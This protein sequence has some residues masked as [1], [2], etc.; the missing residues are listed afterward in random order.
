MKVTTVGGA[1]Q[2]LHLSIEGA[3]VVP[4]FYWVDVEP[5]YGTYVAMRNEGGYWI[6]E[7]RPTSAMVKIQSPFAIELGGPT[8]QHNLMFDPA[9]ALMHESPGVIRKEAP[10]NVVAAIYKPSDVPAAI[11]RSWGDAPLAPLTFRSG[12]PKRGRRVV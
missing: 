5:D 9:K 7:H 6:Q 2:L 3:K 12:P 8:I 4:H 1:Y 10:R 11:R